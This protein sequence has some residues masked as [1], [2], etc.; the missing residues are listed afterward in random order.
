MK[1]LS[2]ES[3]G[4]DLYAERVE[5]TCPDPM[6]KDSTVSHLFKTKIRLSGYY[7]D[8]FFDNVNKEPI[9][10]SCNCGRKFKFQWFRDRVE[11][12]WDDAK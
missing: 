7:D 6:F 10:L 5:C 4:R 11:F 3:M 1:T 9:N 12:E 8:N 2:Y